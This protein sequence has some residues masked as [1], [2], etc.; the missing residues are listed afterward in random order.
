MSVQCSLVFLTRFVVVVVGVVDCS[1]AAAWSRVCFVVE[2]VVCALSHEFDGLVK[3][4]DV[5][6]N[7]LKTRR[8]V[9]GPSL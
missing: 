5:L 1:S 7:W 2:Q 9:V 8:A 6:C 4:R 3:A